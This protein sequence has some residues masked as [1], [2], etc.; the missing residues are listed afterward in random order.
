MNKKHLLIVLYILTFCSCAQRRNLVYFSTLNNQETELLL[1]D[2]AVVIQQN[3]LLRININ[4]LS[5]ESNSLFAVTRQG[6]GLSSVEPTGYR[7]GNDGMVVLP[8]IGSFKVEGMTVPQSQE[9]LIK[10]L[11]KYVK[12]PIVE[13]QLT[14]FKVTVI[15]EVN[16]PSSFTVP[17]DHINLLEALGLAG[18]MTVYGKRENVLIIRE[19]K[20]KRIMKRIDLNDKDILNDPFFN[21]KQNDIVY[22]EPDKAKAVEYSQSTRIMPVV[23]AS[24]SAVAVLISAILRTR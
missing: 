23:I 3:D 9:A 13:V 12:E 19:E 20:G 22:V 15:G 18:D 17:S 4:S 11:A 8:V 21:L 7:V 2:K 24:I 16:R 10:E 1:Q 6:A 5:P 14:N